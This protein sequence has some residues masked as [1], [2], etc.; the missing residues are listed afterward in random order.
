MMQLAYMDPQAVTC[1]PSAT[2]D[3]MM[4]SIPAGVLHVT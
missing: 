4:L 2:D 3:S 1:H